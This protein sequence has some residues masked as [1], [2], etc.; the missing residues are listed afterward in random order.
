MSHA[1]GVRHLPD[2][3]A[4]VLLTLTTTLTACSGPP[5]PVVDVGAFAVAPAPPTRWAGV[6]SR[7]DDRRARAYQ[8]ADPR[9]LRRVYVTGSTLLRRD[10][11]MLHA[12]DER[13]VRLSGVRL[14]LL[15][16]RLLERHRAQVRLRVVDRLARPTAHTV[17]GATVLP[18]DLPTRRT[19]VLRRSFGE[20]RIA[21][22]RR[23]A[24]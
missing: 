17:A 10:R 3:V 1:C 8:R 14:E 24:G 2:A 6:L 12:Y 9:L 15:R 22:V 18:Q 13:H 5:A 19:V 16:V 23:L 4:V 20:W 7:L 11:R 21:A